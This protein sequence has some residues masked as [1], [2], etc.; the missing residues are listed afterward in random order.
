MYRAR[1]LQK[2]L[3]GMVVGDK[4]EHEPYDI[5]CVPNGWIFIYID[6][7][8]GVANVFIPKLKYAYQVDEHITTLLK[9]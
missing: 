2:R 6:S 7:A 3:N 5:L 9:K 4:I 8:I 1:D